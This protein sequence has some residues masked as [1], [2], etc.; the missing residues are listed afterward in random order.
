MGMGNIRVNSRTIIYIYIYIYIYISHHDIL[1]VDIEKA[2]LKEGSVLEILDLVTYE[3]SEQMTFGDI[4][5]MGK[6]SFHALMGDKL[7]LFGGRNDGGFCKGLYKLDLNTFKWDNLSR[8]SV[9]PPLSLGGSVTSGT[10]L[11]FFGGVG[12]KINDAKG[13]YEPCK[14]LGYDFDYGWNNYL[15]EYDTFTSMFHLNIIGSEWN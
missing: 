1:C 10:S 15:Q 7:Y 14:N 3:W 8:Y 13:S 5:E 9:S 2:E 4:P 6:D 12:H 11:F